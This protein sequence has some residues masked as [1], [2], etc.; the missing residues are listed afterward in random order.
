VPLVPVMVAQVCAR[1]QRAGGA[2]RSPWPTELW[3]P[4]CPPLLGLEVPSVDRP[5]NCASQHGVGYLSPEG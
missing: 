3:F 5:P 4:L 1:A 2:H